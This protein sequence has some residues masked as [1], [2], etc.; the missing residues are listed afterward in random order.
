MRQRHLCGGVQTSRFVMAG[1]VHGIAILSKTAGTS[2][3][4][5]TRA[6]NATSSMRG[7][8]INDGTGHL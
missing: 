6:I 2:P 8:V 3:A 1:L 7:D 4:R 5:T